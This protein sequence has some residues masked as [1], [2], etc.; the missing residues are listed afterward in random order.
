[1]TSELINPNR[2]KLDSSEL[3]LAYK[4]VTYALLGKPEIE[5]ALAILKKYYS[6]NNPL[7]DINSVLPEL[8]S[9]TPLCMASY[10]GITRI[11]DFL[12]KNGA[13]PNLTLDNITIPLH[14][15]TA[16]GHITA[17][18]YLLQAGADIDIESKTGQTAFM[19]ACELPP[20]KGSDSIK[21]LLSN[22]LNLMPNIMKESHENKTG[23][24]YALEKNH[25]EIIRIVEYVKLK[26]NTTKKANDSPIRR[27]KI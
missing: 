22:G 8:G 13:Q 21:M 3:E 1:M 12:L 5:P 9:F 14:L 2:A 27:T 17:M 11:V 25:F 7:L 23:L 10:Q 16:N 24:D 6:K 4:Q 20:P 18:F 26:L 15:A 19:R